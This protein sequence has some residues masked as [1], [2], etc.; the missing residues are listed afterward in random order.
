MKCLLPRDDRVFGGKERVAL[1]VGSSSNSRHGIM[2]GWFRV[3]SL[4]GS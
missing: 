3:Q 2:E 1:D 4:G